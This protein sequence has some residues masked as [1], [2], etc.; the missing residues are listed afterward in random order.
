MLEGAGGN[1]AASIG[2]DGIVIVDGGGDVAARALEHVDVAG[3]FRRLDLHLGKIL[4]LLGNRRWPSEQDHSRRRQN[5]P[6]SCLPAHRVPPQKIDAFYQKRSTG[7]ANR[8][9]TR[10]AGRRPE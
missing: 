6:S 8:P 10:G 3:N 2:E 4:V 9:A 1:I 7:K 5:R